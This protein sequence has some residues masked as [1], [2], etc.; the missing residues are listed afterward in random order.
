MIKADV[1][2]YTECLLVGEPKTYDLIRDMLISASRP[3]RTKK[4]HIG[5]DEAGNLGRGKYMDMFGYKPTTQIMH[6]HL[7]KVMEIINELGLEPM[8]WDAY[9]SRREAIIIA[10]DIPEAQSSLT[11]R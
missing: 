11:K 8:M 10:G 3:F 1:K 6:D 5:M 2:D 7:E 9:C 4:I